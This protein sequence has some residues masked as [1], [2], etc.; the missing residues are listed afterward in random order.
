MMRLSSILILLF[1]TGCTFAEINIVQRSVMESGESLS[2]SS[3]DKNLRE[4]STQMELV[5]PLK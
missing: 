1:M 3:L 4:E 2:N 5:V